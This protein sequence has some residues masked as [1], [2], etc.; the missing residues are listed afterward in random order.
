MDLAKG[1]AGLSSVADP[2]A[3]PSIHATGSPAPRSDHLTI[4]Q[5]AA[6]DLPAGWLDADDEPASSRRVRVR[7]VG[8]ID[9]R[10]AAGSRPPVPASRPLHPRSDMKEP[11]MAAADTVI[12]TIT[13]HP[14]AEVAIENPAVAGRQRMK[15]SL[16]GVAVFAAT[17]AV[18]LSVEE[19][20]QAVPIDR[21]GA[22]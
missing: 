3:Q 2:G 14:A 22:V 10:G 11:A 18:G 5:P 12:A 4:I 8:V 1:H 13:D 6:K 20:A 21:Q 16:L 15:R 7:P 9:G 19:P 17:L